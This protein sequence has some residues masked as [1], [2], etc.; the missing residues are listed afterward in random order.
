MI[1]VKAVI[2]GTV[3]VIFVNDVDRDI[4]DFERQ[5]VEKFGFQKKEH[6]V[7]KEIGLE[8]V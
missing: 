3:C 4:F 6:A 7:E 2:K 1:I 5:M 8:I